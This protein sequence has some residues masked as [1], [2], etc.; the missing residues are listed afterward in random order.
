MFFIRNSL[1]EAK[2]CDLEFE[3][4]GRLVRLIFEDLTSRIIIRA[5]EA[6]MANLAGRFIKE[7][8]FG[9]H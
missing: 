2:S 3:K 6:D 8:L 5:T 1:F 7:R 4:N 9:L